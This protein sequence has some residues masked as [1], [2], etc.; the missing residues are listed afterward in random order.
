MR[1]IAVVGSGPA[2]CYLADGLLR[3]AKDSRIDIIDRLPTPFG[4]VRCGV[5]PDHQ[6]TKAV[7]RLLERTLARPEVGFFGGVELGRDVMLEE[8]RDLYDG[9][10]LATGA[11]RDRRLGIPGEDLLGVFP[12][13]RFVGWYNPHPDHAEV[14]LSAVR[15]VVVI[16]NGNVALDVARILAKTTDEFR[17]SDLDPS[18]AAAIDAAPIRQIHIV[19]RRAARH[20]KFTPLELSEFGE[21]GRAR[22]LLAAGHDLEG[23][24]GAASGALRT[25][26]ERPYSA[27][28]IEIR[29][30]FGMTPLRFVGNASGRL[31]AVRFRN[32]D[33]HESELAAELAVTC[34]GYET[35]GHGLAVENGAL[36]NEGGRIAEGLYAVGW[37]RR[38]PSGTIPTNRTE[39]QELAL[40]LLS[41]LSD[42]NKRGVTGLH[43]IVERREIAC[44]DYAGWRR[45]DASEIAGAGEA[46]CRRK[47]RSMHQLF[48]AAT[49]SAEEAPDGDRDRAA[50]RRPEADARAVARAPL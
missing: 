50:A 8:L 12:S 27:D 30:A 39:A 4:L 45:I 13:G 16:G 24:E 29:F 44:I 25:V 1:H 20:M 19:G 22:P 28:R 9:V 14:D 11:S 35:S 33:G 6:S 18:I 17:G 2:G 32:E 41:E 38:G 47:W 23:I 36:A 31:S 7:T 15:S 49:A 3:N 34:I 43:E 37:A 21:L 46:R 40:R 42:G 48:A 26:C 10:V 5:A